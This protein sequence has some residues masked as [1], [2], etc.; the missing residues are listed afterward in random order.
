[1]KCPFCDS[2]DIKVI[3]SRPSDETNTIKRRRECIKCEGRFTTYE[4]IETLPIIVIKRDNSRQPFEREK[5]LKGL[6]RACAKRPVSRETLDWIVDK[7]EFQIGN[8]LEGEVVSTEIGEMV[9]EHLREVDE[10]AYVR[11]ASVY[12]DFADIDTFMRELDKLKKK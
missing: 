12:R 8:E 2:Q 7:I 1:M 5:I 11:F 10:V 9:L 3:D 4:K 6:L